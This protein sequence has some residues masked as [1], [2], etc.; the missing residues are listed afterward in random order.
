MARRQKKWNTEKGA[1]QR[2][3]CGERRQKMKASRR[4]ISG[5]LGLAVDNGSNREVTIQE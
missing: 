5:G 1:V 4:W 3:D 2:F